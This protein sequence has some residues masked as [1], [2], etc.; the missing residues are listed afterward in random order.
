MPKGIPKDKLP[1][2][3]TSAAHGCRQK[4]AKIET[5]RD[6]WYAVNELAK[7]ATYREISDYLNE[8]ND[9]ALTPQQVAYDIHKAMVEWKRENMANIEG[10]IATEVARLEQ[11]EQKI[12]KD[13]EHSKVLRP[14]EY[15]ALMKR[16]MSVEKIDEMYKSRPLAGNPAFL[17]TLLRLQKQRLQLLGIDKG[18]DVPQ[19][20]VI[21]Y[22]FGGLSDDALAKIADVLQDNKSKE[23]LTTLSA[24]NQ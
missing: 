22:N 1:K 24:D 12:L 2:A 21:Q 17:D 14:N 13:Y 16:G 7:G 23:I 10:Y 19:N 8:H 6:I 20:T 5:E 18:S 15:A 11:I 9:Y 3:L 4:R